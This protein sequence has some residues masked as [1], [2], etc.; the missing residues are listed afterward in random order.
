M[1][2]VF[3]GT[4]DF[5]VP[6]LLGLHEEYDIAAVL[7]QP[8]KP[9]GRGHKLAF[10]PAK[11][12]ALELGLPVLQPERVTSIGIAKLN[13]DVMITAAYGQI[14]SQKVLDTPKYGVLNVHASLLPKYRGAAPAQ[15]AVINGEKQTG[16]TIMQTARGVDCGD[17]LLQ[18]A[19]DIMPEETAG[20][21]LTRLAP[22]GRDLLLETLQQKTL[23]PQKQ[24]NEA[25]THAPMLEKSDGE[26]DFTQDA[27]AVY[28]RFRGV[29]PNPGA[30]FIAGEKAIKVLECT[31]ENAIDIKTFSPGEYINCNP[32]TGWLIACRTG[33]LRLQKIQAPG[34]KPMS[35]NDY[36]RGNPIL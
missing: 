18:K 8:D 25:A 11:Q 23:H 34:K 24:N 14:L 5:A 28:N 27:L 26:L 17:I 30:W 16:V 10:S 35:P 36:L 6:I 31:P 20:E 13:A 4:P 1:R 22:L 7:T 32:K 19:I 3:C 15:W 29:T 12:A 33:A 2:I 21:L 9:V